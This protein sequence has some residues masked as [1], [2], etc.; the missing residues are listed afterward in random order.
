LRGQ[1]ILYHKHLNRATHNSVALVLPD[2]NP[3]VVKVVLQKMDER[4]GIVKLKEKKP[5][6]L[7][8]DTRYPQMWVL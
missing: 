7:P 4:I 8:L 5:I 6:F 2:K 3:Y 1:D